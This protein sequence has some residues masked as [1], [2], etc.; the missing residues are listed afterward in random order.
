LLSAEVLSV[1]YAIISDSDFPALVFGVIFK[2]FDLP[3]YFLPRAKCHVFS[4]NIG[5]PDRYGQIGIQEN[6][7]IVNFYDYFL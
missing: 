2:Q 4:R 3:E 7:L 1:F 5:L 6:R